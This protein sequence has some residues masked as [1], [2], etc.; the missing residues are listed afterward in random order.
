MASVITR[1]YDI[2]LFGATGFTGQYVAREL[3]RVASSEKISWA[4]AGRNLEKMKQVLDSVHQVSG[5]KLISSPIM[6]CKQDNS[7]FSE[8]STEEV[9]L[10]KADVE[11]VDS[12]NL[13]AQKG[14]TVLNCVGPYRY[15][16]AYLVFQKYSV[17]MIHNLDSM[18]KL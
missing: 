9:G 4:I 10:I 12:L 16:K 18:V 3:A 2:I 11:D 15:I 5:R 14:R 8:I 7:N 6:E 13:M 17:N 1:K